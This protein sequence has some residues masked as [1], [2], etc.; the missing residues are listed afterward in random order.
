M[1]STF[2]FFIPYRTTISTMIEY[3]ATLKHLAIEPILPTQM[4]KRQR[5]GGGGGA[6][7]NSVTKAIIPAKMLFEFT[8]IPATNALTKYTLSPLAIVRVVHRAT[9]VGTLRINSSP[10]IAGITMPKALNSPLSTPGLVQLEFPVQF[11]IPYK[12]VK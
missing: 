7:E 4:L 6:P 8:R 11:S 1:Y 10:P 2:M 12:G 5:R 3:P 9:M